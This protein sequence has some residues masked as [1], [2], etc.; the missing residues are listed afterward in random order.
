MRLLQTLTPRR[1]PGSSFRPGADTTGG[2]AR[3]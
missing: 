3:A 1:P 2:R